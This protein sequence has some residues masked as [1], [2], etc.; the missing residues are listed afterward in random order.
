MKIISNDSTT[1][2]I[3]CKP[4][5]LR[6][7][8]V[9]FQSRRMDRGINKGKHIFKGE[10]LGGVSASYLSMDGDNTEM[11]LLLTDVNAHGSMM[12]IKPFVAYFYRDNSAIGARFGYTNMHGQIDTATLDLGESND[13]KFTVPYVMYDSD[14]FS[15]GVFF[16]SYTP[17]DRRGNI[18]LFAEV[19]AVYSSG[20]STFEYEDA[21]VVQSTTSVNRSYDLTFNPGISAFVFNNVSATLSFQFG[22]LNYTNIKQ[23]DPEGNYM[24]TRES[25]KMRFMFNVFA[26]KFGMNFHIW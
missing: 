4:I 10:L 6:N 17:L 15:Y 3:P 11:Y 19:E 13:L 25:S 9:L 24:G 1:I 22:G 8:R 20:E 7:G 18:A 5:V 23:Y 21:G 14:A 26:I 16:R 2:V 12:S